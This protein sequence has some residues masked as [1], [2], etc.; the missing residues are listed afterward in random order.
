[1]RWVRRLT[2]GSA[3]SHWPRPA[4][5]SSAGVK[6]S[7]TR[8]PNRRP[9]SVATSTV[10]IR[11]CSSWCGYLRP[12]RSDSDPDDA[13][14]ADPFE[15]RRGRVEYALPVHDC[16]DEER[17]SDHRE[18]QGRRCSEQCQPPNKPTARWADRALPCRP[19]PQLFS[20]LFVHALEECGVGAGRVG[21]FPEADTTRSSSTACLLVD[22]PELRSTTAEQRFDGTFA[23]MEGACDVA[24]G[25]VVDVME[26]E[27]RPLARR[28]PAED[29]EDVGALSCD[30]KGSL[31]GGA[32]ISRTM[33]RRCRRS[34]RSSRR[35]GRSACCDRSR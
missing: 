21:D 6:L 13:G 14:L 25:E 27:S 16:P 30:R 18:R 26:D 17:A 4:S 8:R 20:E 3:I 34:S 7:S 32:E 24:N 9:T 2:D 15:Q 23:P 11:E 5:I 1:M 22:L 28:E 35:N 10:K 31:D 19:E 33:S 29:G 12:V